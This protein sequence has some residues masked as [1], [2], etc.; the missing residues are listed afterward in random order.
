MA[1]LEDV[2]LRDTR[3]S[4]P[5]ANAV[6]VGTIYYV[7]DE[8]VTERSNGTSWDDISDAGSG[9][10]AAAIHDDTSG[11]INAI[12][13]KASPVS[14]D[15]ILI[16]DSEA[17]NAKKKVQLGNLPGGAGSV[18]DLLDTL[19]VRKT[20]DEVV[21]ASATLQDDDELVMPI[22][23]NE[24]WEYELCI[25]WGNASNA[26][27]DFKYQITAPSGAAGMKIQ[28]GPATATSAT[29]NTAVDMAGWSTEDFSATP[30][31]VGQHATTGVTLLWI[32]VLVV[33]GANSGN[34]Q[35]QWA[36][37]SSQSIDTTVYAHSFMIGRRW[38]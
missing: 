11:E 23:A 24:V 36:Q 29:D 25:K 38:T 21:N 10:D 3:A 15:L 27:A 18:G 35:F 13:E 7:T 14:A 20:S 32:R 19:F 34:V 12:T 16:E 30:I 4:Q 6:A 2:I 8:N 26:S 17:S 28:V 1:L 31:A 9:T 37:N 5:A 33:N 22:G